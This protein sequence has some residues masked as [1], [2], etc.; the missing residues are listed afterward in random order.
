MAEKDG[1]L[2]KHLRLPNSKIG[3]LK[4]L[5]KARK[6]EPF[7][8]VKPLKDYV[9]EKV[10]R[11]PLN[12]LGIPTTVTYSDISGL[13][14]RTPDGESPAVEAAFKSAGLP[15]LF[16]LWE[17]NGDAHA[18]GGIC[19]NLPVSYFDPMVEGEIICFTFPKMA[20]KTIGKFG[21]YLEK[22]VSTAIDHT[23]DRSLAGVESYHAFEIPT[24]IETF[25]F[26]TAFSNK[27]LS[28]KPGSK[29]QAIMTAT[30]EFFGNLQKKSKLQNDEQG[31]NEMVKNILRRIGEAFE[32]AEWRPKYRI[33]QFRWEIV[34][35]TLREP[36]KDCILREKMIFSPS[37]A[38]IHYMITSATGKPTS[39]P[40][41][42]A[43]RV[44][45]QNDQ[46]TLIKSNSIA[47]IDKDGDRGILTV[48]YSPL[49]ESGGAEKYRQEY[50]E[51]RALGPNDLDQM[52]F[53]HRQAVGKIDR[54]E[55][56]LQVPKERPGV[57]F[58][59]RANSQG[60]R[61][62]KEGELPQPKDGY[63]CI[64]HVWEDTEPLPEKA[65]EVQIVS[66][67]IP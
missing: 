15:I 4:L 60:G 52:R 14:L 19:D 53:L 45:R 63:Y 44:Y 32:V 51:T 33:H 18:D 16:N 3:L 29:S 12:E 13:C 48:F 58:L 9:L 31:T 55:F 34:A 42:E 28:S 66:P 50:E 11:V 49:L 23:V 41:G 27:F 56:V 38:P 35:V 54:L 10:G 7:W 62:M 59:Q 21:E 36:N 47:M 43:V 64:G 8:D 30:R 25:E 40:P 65:Y 20:P 6:A 17:N 37:G 57:Q 5:W 39:Q 26:D 2:V 67:R 1:T 61:Q 24:D 22:L 46:D